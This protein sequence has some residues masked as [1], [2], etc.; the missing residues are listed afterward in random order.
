LKNDGVEVVISRLNKRKKSKDFVVGVSVARTNDASAS[1]IEAGITDYVFSLKK[2]VEADVADYYTIN[3]SC[4]NSFGGETFSS[5]D[6]L[7][8]LFIEMDKVA[9]VKPLY[10]KMPISIADNAFVQL[11]SVLTRHN[12][13]GVIIGNLQKDY[14][15]IDARDVIPNG[16]RGG[17][18]GKPCEERSNELIAL[19]RTQYK[20]RFT[21]V[22]CGGVFSYEDAKRKFDLG[23]DLI[24]L[25]TGMI[26][27]GPGLIKDICR[28]IALQK[29][30]K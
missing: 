19:T 15:T 24:Q 8:R 12:V 28:G 26:Y 5:P 1:T 7:E 9:Q 14:S 21:I 11:L 22:G 16:Y 6:L 13:Q 10:V 4:P 20:D 3:I 27:E 17:L 25:I 29:S 2:L 30:E 23:A 18:S